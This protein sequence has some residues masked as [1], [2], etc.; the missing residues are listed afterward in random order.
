MSLF[1]G[2]KPNVQFIKENQAAWD[3]L[4]VTLRV[5]FQAK[6]SSA[7]YNRRWKII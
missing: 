1:A 3:E 2:S 7:Y 4:Y 6:F 5:N